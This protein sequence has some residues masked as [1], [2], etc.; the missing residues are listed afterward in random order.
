MAILSATEN[1]TKGLGKN[2]EDIV[3]GDK[4][5]VKT[6]DRVESAASGFC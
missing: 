6:T 3:D 2:H 1:N 5:Q 4:R